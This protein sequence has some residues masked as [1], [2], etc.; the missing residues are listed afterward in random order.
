MSSQEI[1]RVICFD[2]ICI[3]CNVFVDL[4]MRFDKK[5]IFRYTS[6]QGQWAKEH[7]SEQCI[8][9]AASITFYRDGNLYTHSTAVLMIFF[10]LGGFYRLSAIFFLIPKL[11]RDFIY[12]QVAK[13]RYRLFGKKDFCRI[14]KEH[15][16]ELFIP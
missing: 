12:T 2:G 10:D 11:I 3:L 14:P 13:N 8:Q 16:K 7:L 5:K 9:Q 15:E 1:T 6:L 4:L